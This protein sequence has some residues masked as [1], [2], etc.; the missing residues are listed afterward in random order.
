M[1]SCAFAF[2]C[3]MNSAS[4]DG[5]SFNSNAESSSTRAA[6][7]S[8]SASLPPCAPPL[9][10]IFFSGELTQ[11]RWYGETKSEAT[12]NL[13]CHSAASA[14]R[15]RRSGGIC[16]SNSSDGQTLRSP[17]PRALLLQILMRDQDMRPLFRHLL[18]NRHRQLYIQRNA[19]GIQ[20]FC[21]GLF[22][23]LQH[24]FVADA[25]SSLQ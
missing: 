15:L 6:E 1:A 4:R 14:P 17:K 23:G 12:R 25:E 19:I 7:T 18:T 13:S 3:P 8:R 24:C 22:G 2:S 5:R 21:F 9:K 20:G 11:R 16:F 10:S